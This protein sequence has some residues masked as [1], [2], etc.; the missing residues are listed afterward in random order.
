MMRVRF[1]RL[2]ATVLALLAL[3]AVSCGGDD[4]EG[5]SPSPS[6]PIGVEGDVETQKFG[7]PDAEFTMDGDTKVFELTAAP[8]TIRPREDGQE[9]EAWGY[10][11]QVPGPTIRVHTGDKFR[12]VFNNEL[13]EHSTIHPHGLIVPNAMDGVGG[14]TQDPVLPGDSFTYEYTIPD[15]AGTFMYHAHMNDLMQVRMGLYGAFIVEGDDEPKFDQERIVLLSDTE[16]EFMIN[17]RSFP[18]T[19]AWEVEPGQHIRARLINISSVASHPMHLHGH[20]MRIIAR[21]G[22]LVSNAGQ[23]L[24]ENTI[25]MDVGQTAD[26]EVVMDNGPGTWIFHC[27][28]LNHVMGPEPES[29]DITKANGG[30]VIA[31]QYVDEGA[32]RNAAPPP[33]ARQLI[34][35]GGAFVHH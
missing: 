14:L 30:M 28:V 32:T 10:N 1:L 11:G 5:A 7:P 25:G 22:T 12:L 4:D 19:E 13:P 2:G 6:A 20:F 34:E 16:G 21:D 33:T 3:G 27:H 23:A 9:V 35:R 17:G 15:T 8:L 29:A 24:V 18:D 31:I 26:V